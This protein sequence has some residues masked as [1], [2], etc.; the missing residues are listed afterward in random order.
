MRVIAVCVCLLAC[1]PIFAQAPKKGRPVEFIEKD[2]ADAKKRLA[3]L[4]AELAAAKP[5]IKG[6]I[7]PLA[8]D[9]PEVGMSGF[10]QETFEIREILT[11]DLMLVSPESKQSRRFVLKRPTKNE[12]DGKQFTVMGVYEFT[13][14]EK[15][16]M[17][18][19]YVLEFVTPPKVVK[20]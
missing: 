5:K 17:R 12:A 3:A 18:T 14:T 2:I 20:D 6:A 9:M 1:G 13:G 8:L 15:V 10:L 19:Y 11:P 4:E 16:G 7:K